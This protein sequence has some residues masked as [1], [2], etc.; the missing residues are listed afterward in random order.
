MAIR[1]EKSVH[2][3]AILGGILLE[4]LQ[5][6]GVVLDLNHIVDK[7]NRSSYKMWMGNGEG[8]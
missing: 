2:V 3:E 4:Y 1:V 6:L 8:Q 7:E 5:S